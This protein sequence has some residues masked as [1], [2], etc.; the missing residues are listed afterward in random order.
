MTRDKETGLR[1]T[2]WLDLLPMELEAIT[3]DQLIEPEDEVEE[4][5]QEIGTLPLFLKKLYTRIAQLRAE[6]LRVQADLAMLPA[7]KKRER[8]RLVVKTVELVR[9]HATL[10]DIFWIAVNEEFG[11]WMAP[12][13]SLRPGW[14]LMRCSGG[15][16]SPLSLFRDLLG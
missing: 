10:R 6:C 7:A 15:G 1:T 12:N 9:K 11:L 3:E 13:L 8:E 5:E 16:S 2:F 14:K 4:G